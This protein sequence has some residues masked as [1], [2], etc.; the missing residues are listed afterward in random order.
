MGL[1]IRTITPGELQKY[2]QVPC[3]FQ[4]D[5]TLIVEPVDGGLGGLR[6]HEEPVVSPYTKDYDAY[7]DGWPEDWPRQFDVRNWG[8]FL[9]LEGERPV[10]GAAVAWR[11]P[12]VHMLADRDDMAVLWDIRVHPDFRHQGLGRQIFWHA[13]SW[14]REQG[15]RLLKIETQNVN[16]RACRFYH[17]Q[18]CRLGEINCYGYAGVP[19]VAHE[20]MLIWYLDL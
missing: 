3:A 6:M 1:E 11:T 15:A 17:K 19:R 12:G 7:E 18:G 14:P 5:S 10:A 2:G 13:A 8:F 16:V 4:V 20:V 9:A